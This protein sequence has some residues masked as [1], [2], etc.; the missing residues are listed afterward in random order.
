MIQYKNRFY[1]IHKTNGCGCCSATLELQ[2]DARP[3]SSGKKGG[4]G[5]VRARESAQ[6]R[7]WIQVGDL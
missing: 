5:K 6:S 3:E 7:V 2:S 1:C 4:R